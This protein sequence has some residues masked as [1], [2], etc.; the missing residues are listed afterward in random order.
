MQILNIKEYEILIN[1]FKPFTERILKGLEDFESPEDKIRY[2]KSEEVKY[3]LEV[4]MNQE[5][6]AASGVVTTVRSQ[7]VGLD[8]WI[9]IKIKEIENT[10]IPP[11]EPIKT[12]YVW[13]SEPDRELPELHKLMID[14]YKLIAPETT[15]EQFKAA[16]TGQSLASF[17]PIKWHQ[18]NA[19]ELLYFILRLE[20]TNNIKHNPKRADYKRMTSCFVKPNGDQFKAVWKSLKTNLSIN[21]SEDKQTA[22]D[23]LL[24]NF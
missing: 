1:H 11:K 12:S 14:K 15:L 18:D 21:L 4:S 19:S 17:E 22:I 6:M 3:L 9:D 8:N 24:D 2:L 7:K 16:F 5:L 23:E 10:L 20:Q 13:Y